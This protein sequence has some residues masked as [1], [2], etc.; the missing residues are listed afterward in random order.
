MQLVRIDTN[1]SA[2]PDCS[3]ESG[4]CACDIEVCRRNNLKLA[5]DLSTGQDLCKNFCADMKQIPSEHCA[6]CKRFLFPE[7]NLICS[8]QNG[9]TQRLNLCETDTVCRK[10]FSQLTKKQITL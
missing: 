5:S 9:Q 7:N 1:N 8:I 10:C 3:C 4:V 6:C 2:V